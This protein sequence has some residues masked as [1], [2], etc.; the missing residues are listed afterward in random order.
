MT[1]PI[2]IKAKSTIKNIEYF[3]YHWSNFA[4]NTKK[5]NLNNKD[6]INSNNRNRIN[7]KQIARALNDIV[8]YHLAYLQ[9]ILQRTIKESD[10]E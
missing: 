4:V 8:L 5:N 9:K 2:T 6:F 7:N 3:S 1:Y 10:R